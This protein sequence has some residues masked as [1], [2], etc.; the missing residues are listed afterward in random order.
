MLAHFFVLALT[1]AK[2]TLLDLPAR[3]M[4]GW[5]PGT[6]GFCGSMSIQTSALYYGNWIT[7]AAV[8]GVTGGTD[9]SH[10]IL[11][12]GQDETGE[13]CG[14]LKA[15]HLLGL[16]ATA[17]DTDGANT[18]QHKAYLDWARA[19]INNGNPVVI[20]VYMNGF[21]DTDY[22]HIVPMVGFD[23]GAIFFNDLHYNF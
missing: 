11:L 2:P 18:P 14:A 22:D 15:C 20:T 4:W 13:C 6:S 10:E 1:H 3:Y 7:Q 16:N 19:A 9:A 23:E 8:R 21:K 17:F 5:G 12:Y